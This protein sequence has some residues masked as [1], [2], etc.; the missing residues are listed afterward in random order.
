MLPP[1]GGLAVV[2]DAG[3]WRR[4]RNGRVSCSDANRQIVGDVALGRLRV[5]AEG[6]C[7]LG[8]FLRLGLVDA[9]DVGLDV[10]DESEPTVGRVLADADGDGDRRL[11]GNRRSGVLGGCTQSAEEAGRVARREELL[12]VAAFSAAAEFLRWAQVQIDLSACGN[13]LAVAAAAGRRGRNGVSGFDSQV[14][15]SETQI[16]RDWVL[17]MMCYFFVL[18]QLSRPWCSEIADVQQDFS[19]A[20]L[21][22]RPIRP[23]CP[24]PRRRCA[25]TRRLARAPAH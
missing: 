11:V 1:V 9:G 20:G 23:S 15:S 2:P 12:G 4:A 22:G 19:S 7:A 10:G 6:V 14:Y 21:R 18:Q 3:L 24:D 17:L 8:E 16:L 25:S 13:D 5:G